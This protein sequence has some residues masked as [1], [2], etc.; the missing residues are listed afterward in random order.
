[1]AE[2]STWPFTAPLAHCVCPVY[3]GISEKPKWGLR[4]V[5][6]G[7]SGRSLAQW[8]RSIYLHT[9]IEDRASQVALAVKIQLPMQEMEETQVQHW[10]WKI[11]GGEHGSPL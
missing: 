2:Q 11:P 1:M 5:L 3:C 7:L 6:C 8:S 4:S 9:L 10:V